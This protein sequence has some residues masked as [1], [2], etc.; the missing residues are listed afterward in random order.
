MCSSSKLLTCKH[1]LEKESS[2]AS[3]RSLSM[4]LAARAACSKAAGALHRG[5]SCFTA[6]L[7]QTGHLAAISGVHSASIA[8][9]V[10]SFC[11]QL[12][13][14]LV[15]ASRVQAVRKITAPPTGLCSDELSALNSAARR[16]VLLSLAQVGRASGAP[17]ALAMLCLLWLMQQAPYSS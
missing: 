14:G 12:Q 2:S 1:H 8:A 6:L 13:P 15:Q 10:H 3:C 4:G 17:E 7:G 11:V 5:T 9:T 16:R